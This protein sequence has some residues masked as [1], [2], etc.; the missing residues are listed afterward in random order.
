M[1][2][3]KQEYSMVESHLKTGGE[4]LEFQNK[5]EVTNKI[6]TACQDTFQ[7]LKLRRKHRYIIFKL[8]DEE[9]EVEN[10]G[11]RNASFEQLT[12]VLPFTDCRFCIYDQDYKTSDGR[13]ASKLWF[14]SWFPRNSTTHHK[15]AYTSA[16]GKF[17][18]TIPG[19]FDIQVSSTE[20][21]AVGLGLVKEEEEEE[22]DFD[23]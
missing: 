13:P 15:M 8:G 4:A 12:T 5:V 6:S 1:T 2:D 17:R 7:E 23:F 14:I 11:E 19:V 9:I 18:E 10:V 3:P 16:K 20:E 21:L 22:E